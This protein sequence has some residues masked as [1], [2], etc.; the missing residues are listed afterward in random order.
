MASMVAESKRFF[1][2]VGPEINQAKPA[3]NIQSLSSEA[4]YLEGT[5]GYKYLGILE[6]KTG[7]PTEEAWARIKQ[8]ILNRVGGCVNCRSAVETCSE[9]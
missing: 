5:Q 6:D 8:E 2:T 4:V 7:R 3:T 1:R 9:L